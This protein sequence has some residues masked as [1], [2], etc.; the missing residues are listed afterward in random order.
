MIGQNIFLFNQ[1]Y[2]EGGFDLSIH[3]EDVWPV[4]IHVQN[5][6]VVP[7]IE[8][9]VKWTVMPT[10]QGIDDDS[11]RLVPRLVAML[12]IAS[13][14]SVADARIQGVPGKLAARNLRVSEP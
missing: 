14:S 3:E 11:N 9:L 2:L 6:V 8:M 7:D 13:S 5:L 10:R 1:P 12:A 4:G